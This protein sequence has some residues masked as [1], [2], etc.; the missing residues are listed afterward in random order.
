MEG[1]YAKYNRYELIE[2]DPLQFVYQYS[3]RGDM[4][5]AGLVAAVLAYGRVQ[6]IEKSV[7][8][9]LGIMGSSPCGFVRDFNASSRRKLRDFT[10]RFNTGDEI[11]DLFVLLKGVICKFGSI[12][13]YF[14]QGYDSNDET[15]I[16]AL[17]KFCDS[18]H[19]KYASRHGGVVS[20]GL[21]YLLSS[22]SA[23]SACKRL[24][25]YLRWMVRSDDVDA[26]VWKSV[27]KAK[28]VV[29][30]DVHMARLCKIM[31]FYD[32][33]TVSL[34]TAL[35]ISRKFATIN[36]ADPVKYDF[37]LSRIGIIENCNGTIRQGCELCCLYE[38]CQ[39]KGVANK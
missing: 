9:L 34:A 18:L 19:G 7:G 27:D 8:K 32:R 5:V 4:E 29:P 31:G 35:E 22:P 39:R 1:V 33:K 21:K 15:V 24:N 38:Y 36:P 10:H 13:D 26:G 6:Q 30:I 37:A 16:P 12:E 20:R 28:L 2:P 14:L 3:G 25:L 17:G 23:G 11:S